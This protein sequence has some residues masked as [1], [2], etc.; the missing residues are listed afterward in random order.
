MDGG[1]LLA[2]RA[3]SGNVSKVSGIGANG[4]EIGRNAGV[5]RYFVGPSPDVQSCLP[6]SRLSSRASDASKSCIASDEK[7]WSEA[8]SDGM[9]EGAGLVAM[10]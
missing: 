1:A 10:P 6:A 4:L 9:G 8:G 7:L 5:S 2:G 3:V